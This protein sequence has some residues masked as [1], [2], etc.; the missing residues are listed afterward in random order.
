MFVQ[1]IQ[2]LVTFRG[3]GLVK[4]NIATSLLGSALEWYTSKLSDFDCD[5]LNNNPGVKSWINTLSRCFK[6]PT[7][8]TL[9]LL[10]DETYSLNDACAW[11]SLAQYICAIMQHG[12][13]CNIVDVANQ[14]S[15]AYQGLAQSFEFLSPLRPN[16]RKHRILYALLR[17]SKKYGTK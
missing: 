10:T 6:I 15:F 4:A 5:A 17:R 13:G 1:Q 12:I 7:S 14:L 16:P 9:S 8:V 3:A 11:R 2:S